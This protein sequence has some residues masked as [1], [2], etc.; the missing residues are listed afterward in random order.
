MDQEAYS[1]SHNLEVWVV[2]PVLLLLHQ[3]SPVS[4]ANPATLPSHGSNSLLT[5]SWSWGVGCAPGPPLA[6]PAKPCKFGKP[7]NPSTLWVKKLT[8]LLMI[9]RYGLCTWSSSSCTSHALYIR[10]TLHPCHPTGQEAYSPCY[11]LEAWVVHP[12][13]QPSPVSLAN[14]APLPPHGSRSLLTFS[15]S[16][17][18][19]CAPGPPPPA[20]VKPCKLGKP[21]I[22]ATPWV[23]KLTHL[24]MILRRG[25]CTLCTS[26]AL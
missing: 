2:H 12:V 17:G 8:H 9:L 21:C 22:P 6:A 5:F 26:Q 14:P 1:P 10:Q 24:V 3:P 25:L 20:P 4:L 23:M 18:V 16:W 11:D 15:W 19:G 7:C 13:H